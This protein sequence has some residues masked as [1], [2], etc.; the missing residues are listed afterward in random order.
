MIRELPLGG[1]E[2]REVAFDAGD[3]LRSLHPRAR[4][5][6][7][8]DVPGLYPASA[9]TPTVDAVD[10]PDSILALLKCAFWDCISVSVTELPGGRAATGVFHVIATRDGE[11]RSPFVAKIASRSDIITE[12]RKF[13]ERARDFVPFTSRPNGLVQR[14]FVLG[15]QGILVSQFADRTVTLREAVRHDGATEAIH[16]LFSSVLHR[17]WANSSLKGGPMLTDLTRWDL[18]RWINLADRKDRDQREEVLTR[19]RGLAVKLL[20]RHVPAPGALRARLTTERLFRLGRIHGDLNC[21]N[22]LIRGGSAI[23]IDFAHCADGPLLADPAWLEV[24][25]VFGWDWVGARPDNDAA[26]TMSAL[27]RAAWVRSVDI[28]YEPSCI[29][30]PLQWHLGEDCDEELRR[31]CSAV[32]IIRRHAFDVSASMGDYAH[33]VAAALMRFASLEGVAHDGR[34]RDA[35][36]ERRARAYCTAWNLIEYAPGQSGSSS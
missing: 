23:M 13:E 26:Q 16:D 33:V 35:D 27:R 25:L 21:G 17:W 8:R 34:A 5:L 4:S 2:V 12:A 22:V 18:S 14:S 7:P 6:P 11:K 28:L 15:S 30:R 29:L 3:L 10:V 20:G 24:N 9:S 19:H 36:E 32:R 1:G 31:L